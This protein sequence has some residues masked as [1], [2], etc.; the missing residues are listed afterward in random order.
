[1]EP[2][3]QNAVVGDNFGTELPQTRVDDTQLAQ[4]KNMA[5]FSRSREFKVLKQHL[6]DRIEFFQTYLPNGDPAAAQG[7]TQESVHNWIIANT[8]IGE[9]RLVLNAYENAAKALEATK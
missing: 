7:V 9:F 8:V 3:A 5:R 6:E 1:M 2:G 4:E